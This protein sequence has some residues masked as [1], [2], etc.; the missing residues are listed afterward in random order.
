[1]RKKEIINKFK[2]KT[3]KEKKNNFNE[4]VLNI[5]RKTQWKWGKMAKKQEKLSE[6]I[7]G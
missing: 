2:E 3:T 4:N 5:H 7:R 1:M 6:N